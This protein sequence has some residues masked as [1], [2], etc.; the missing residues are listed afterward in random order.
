MFY[1][2]THEYGDRSGFRIVGITPDVQA[3]HLWYV[4]ADENHVYRVTPNVWQKDGW[5]RWE[6]R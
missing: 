2:L 4:A 1:V 6:P 3:A 5:E